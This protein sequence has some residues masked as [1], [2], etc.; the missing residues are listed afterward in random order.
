MPGT[1]HRG[2]SPQRL[3]ARKSSAGL[4]CTQT[5]NHEATVQT[6][7]TFSK[8][9]LGPPSDMLAGVHPRVASVKQTLF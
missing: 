8:E 6:L 3:L 9:G 5:L 7:P 4:S 1:R 2:L